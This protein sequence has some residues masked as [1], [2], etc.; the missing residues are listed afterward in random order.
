MEQAA[1]SEFRRIEKSVRPAPQRP[2]KP[3]IDGD[4]KSHFGSFDNRPW[5]STIKNLPQN[6]FA[7]TI[8]EL[9]S[10]RQSPGE[11]DH[12]MIEER[13]PDLETDRHARAIEFGQ[14]IVG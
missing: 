1:A 14:Q 9:E 4:R 8:A 13:G 2:A 11:L 12:P 3:A 6:P 10:M 5:H 7:D